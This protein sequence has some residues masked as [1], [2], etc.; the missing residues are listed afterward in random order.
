VS[1]I[2][3]RSIQQYGLI[4]NEI[5]LRRY[6]LLVGGALLAVLLAVDAINPRQ[7]ALESGNPGPRFP[8]IRIHSEVKGP[9]AVVIDTSRPTIVPPL[10]V[11]GEAA[12]ANVPPAP[13][14][15][16]NVAQLVSSS[17]KQ[18]D[19]KE[20]RAERK[21]QPHSKIARARSKQ[22]PV[23]YAQRPDLGPFDGRWTYDQQN[24]RVRES[25]AQLVPLQQRQN[26]ARRELAWART[27]HARRQNFGWF[28]TGW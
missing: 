10:T 13:Q 6:F 26:G 19:E 22:P 3:S 12:K 21:P 15:A 16:E 14:L 8:R 9:E 1:K 24:A 11:Q 2:F 7:P 23:S 27:E 18:P 28:N 25:F 5:P 20:L 17:Q 4:N